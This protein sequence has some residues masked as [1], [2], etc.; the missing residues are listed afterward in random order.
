MLRPLCVCYFLWVMGAF[1]LCWQKEI[2]TYIEWL[3]LVF[4][5]VQILATFFFRGKWDSDCLMIDGMVSQLGDQVEK[6]WQRDE[7]GTGKYPP[8]SLHVGVM[9]TENS[10]NNNNQPPP[11]SQW[12]LTDRSFLTT[13]N[14]PFQALLDLYLLESIE[15]SY[16]HAIVSFLVILLAPSVYAPSYLFRCGKAGLLRNVKDKTVP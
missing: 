13:C 16:K 6:L 12:F 5:S 3:D 14:F 11:K 1:A 10:S 8:A 15:E 2:L 9:F 4:G 7:G